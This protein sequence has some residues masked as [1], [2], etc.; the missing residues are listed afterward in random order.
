MG[1]SNSSTCD[2]LILLTETWRHSMYTPIHVERH[3][4]LRQHFSY[5]AYNAWESLIQEVYGVPSYP[6]SG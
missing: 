4:L 6:N 5:D 3:I 1:L 2:S